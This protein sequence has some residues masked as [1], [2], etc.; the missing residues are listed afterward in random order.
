MNQYITL[1]GR[2]TQTL[3]GL[4]LDKALARLFCDYSRSYLQSWIRSGFVQIDGSVQKKRRYTVKTGQC[5]V[6]VADFL[7]LK[8]EECWKPQP[9]ALN[10][11]YQDDDIL[12]VNKPA[13]LTVHPGAGQLDQTL[14]NALLHFDPTLNVLPRAG[15]VHRLD[16]DTSGSLV[17][18]RNL[19]A[20][21]HL[22]KAMQLHEICREYRAIV[23]GVMTAGRTI[24]KP[25]GR[26][27]IHRLRMSVLSSGKRAITHYR[28]LERFRVHSYIRV[29]LE[30]GRTHQIRVHLS[31]IYYPLVGDQLY[32]KNRIV[33]GR[34]TPQLK[35]ALF[36]F[37]RQALHA[38]RL[39]LMH[40][41]SKKTM[42]FEAPIPEDMTQLLHLLRKDTSIY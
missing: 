12:V 1:Q 36:S 5:I 34:L 38:F 13:G 24:D 23:T 35:K 39:C 11:I 41:R 6:I 37:K 33:P 27:S 40:P 20:Y 7:K 28:V 4:R 18:A 31:H 30:T 29:I 15:L 22:R 2:I 9:I 25:I 42:N 32:G 14:V 19:Q 3:S 8:R 16:K 21:H 26:H 10:I 17:V